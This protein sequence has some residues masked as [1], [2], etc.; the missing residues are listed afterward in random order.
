MKQNKLWLTTVVLLLLF[1]FGASAQKPKPKKPAKKQTVQKSAPKKKTTAPATTKKPVD[2]KKPADAKQSTNDAATDEK[3]VRDMVAFFEYVLNTLGSRETSARDK[4]VLV[5]QSYAKIFRDGKVQV[6]DDL[7]EEREVITNKDIVAYLKD[8][9]FFYDDVKFEFTIDRIQSGTLAD[10]NQFYKVAA[11]RNLKGTNAEGKPVNNAKQR[12]MEINYDP[13]AGDLKIVSIYTNVFN[14]KE[15]LLTWWKELSYE[16]QAILKRKINLVDSAQYSDI[17]NIIAIQELD[18]SNNQYIQDIE[19]LSPLSRLRLLNLS[20]TAIS[21]LSPIRNLTEL[22]DLNLS[23]TKVLDLNPLRYAAA[24]ERFD[25]SHTPVTDISVVQKMPKLKYL[26][27]RGTGAGDFTILTDLVEMRHLDLSGTGLSSLDNLQNM[28]QLSELDLSRT[29][30]QNLDG[31]KALADLA[32]LDIDTTR[33]RSLAP[34]SGLQNLRVLRASGTSISDLQPLQKLPRLE[35]IYCDQTPI[36]RDIAHAFMAGKPG[37]L[38]IFDSKDLKNWWETL[39]DDWRTV[40]SKTAGIGPTPTDEELARFVNVDSINFSGNTAIKDLEP[41]RKLPRL[42][43]IVAAKTSVTDLS[44]LEGHREITYLDISGS[45]VTSLT[46]VRQFTKLRMLM[47]DD[48]KIEN[49]D[50]LGVLAG[51]QKLYA[52]HSSVHDII[53]REF[54]EKNPQCLL[55]YKTVHLKRWWAG[56]TPEWKEE[57]HQQMGKDTTTTRENMH[58][59]VESEVLKIADAQVNDLSALSEFVRLRELRLSGTAVSNLAPLAN[60]QT[61]KTLQVTGSPLQQ[62]DA[63][64][65]LPQLE[66]LDISNTPIDDLETVGTL[67]ELKKLNCAGTQIKRLDPLGSLQNL[68]YFDCSNTRVTK[69]DDIQHLPLKTLK[70]YNTK[71]SARAVESFKAKNPG[72][73]VMYYR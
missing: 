42:R 1:A 72:C 26:N 33:V 61:L 43:A 62:M 39:D 8:V 30:I 44:P 19:A 59:L 17:R 24:I 71:I 45:G 3:K 28:M 16:W 20:G 6:E 48:S 7:D 68:E 32:I 31:L 2:A 18:L 55:V 22:T 13:R 52:D 56:L 47:A 65:Q 51:L 4:E 67:K 53:A 21:D 29:S 46:V 69:L 11:T 58:R 50:A 64:K 41:L 60:F 73:N 35:K 23:R 25:V 36:T 5:T 70:C 63:L 38:V 27:V 57:F 15:A 10:G 14:E 9:D 66:E 40:L 34:L 37:T 54:L 12:N 49:L